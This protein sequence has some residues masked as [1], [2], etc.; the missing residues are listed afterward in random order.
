MLRSFDDG[1]TWS[2]P[3]AVSFRAGHRDGMPVP[4]LL[5]DKGIVCAIE[6]NGFS[7]MFHVMIVH[8]TDNWNQP[9][10]DGN[11]PRRWKAVEQPIDVEWGGAPYIRQMP[12]GET[13][14]SFQSS[15]GRDKPQMVVYVGD[16]NARNFGGRSVPFKVPK[17]KGGWWGSL[18]V[19]DDRTVTA[20]SSC[21]GGVWAIDGKVVGSG[22]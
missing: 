20:I 13:I 14:L 11:S 10:A 16:E 12:A 2:E 9:A 6:D 5:K 8:T 19:K 1:K 22:F 4:C 7:Q 21:N 18:F 15:V 17:N 3:K